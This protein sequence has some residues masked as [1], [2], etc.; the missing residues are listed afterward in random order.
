MLLPFEDQ[1]EDILQKAAAGLSLGKRQLAAQTGL[2]LE[3][4][5]AALSGDG[6]DDTLSRLA[7]A[8]GLHGPS[9]IAL[10]RGRVQPSPVAFPGLEMVTTPYPVPGYEDMTVNAFLLHRRD[11]M[12]AILFDAG[13]AAEPLLNLLSDRGLHLEAVFLTHAHGDHVQALPDLLKRD[14][15]P[16]VYV[17]EKEAFHGAASFI[18]GRSF[19]YAG[20]RIE[21]RLTCGHSAGGITYVI[22]GMERPVAVVGDALFC[23]SQGGARS[24]YAEALDTNRKAIFSLPDETILCPGHG[25]LTTVAFEKAH[26]PFYPEFK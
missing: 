21:S 7:E 15:V 22:D 4:V 23:C 11:S 14:P 16:P 3:Q 1:V 24:A 20:L 8:V 26:N 2:A 10:A 25:P 17:C 12:A 13:A 6:D 19:E 18:P 9:L 5:R